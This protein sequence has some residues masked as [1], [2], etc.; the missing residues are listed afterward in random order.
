MPYYEHV[1]MTR[2]DISTQQVEA[3]TKE[4]QGVVEELGGKV[5]KTEYWG[6]KSL[7]YK[8]K[9]ARKAHY[10]LMNI[11]APPAAV[12]EME[13]RMGIA[14]DVLR[15]LTV[16]VETLEAEPSAMMR[17]Q[18]RDE[19]D[20]G[21]FG[22]GRGERGPRGERGGERGGGER[23]GGERGGGYRG[24]PGGGGGGGSTFRARPPRDGAPVGEDGAPRGDG[25]RG[26][27]GPRPPRDTSSSGPQE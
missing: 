12:Q 19:R 16:K 3:L 27:R 8:I 20:S 9:K 18:D 17:K 7:A 14:T 10:T 5:T 2:Q 23:G 26:P 4:Y 11:D 13:R 1:F 21:G 6:L 25:P 24:G 22:G 15:F